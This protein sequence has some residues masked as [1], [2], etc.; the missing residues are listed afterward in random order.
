MSG[1]RQTADVGS[2]IRRARGWDASV[3]SE[4]AMRSK[5]HW[6]YDA[7]FLA[8]CRG[9]LALSPE[10]IATSA[11]YISDVD[12]RP[13]GYYRLLPLDESAVDLD[14]FFV[15]PSAIGRG[16]GG[17]LWQHAVATATKLGYSELVMQ[18]DPHAEGFYL[19]M[20]AQRDG[21]SESTV[22]PGRMLPLLRFRPR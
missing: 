11:V 9:D 18:S 16:V 22:M 10:D 20:G 2:G 13:E 3:L 14:A 7:A 15:E 17:R 12:G 4:L 1:D 5:G 6:G 21:T 19:A 8:A